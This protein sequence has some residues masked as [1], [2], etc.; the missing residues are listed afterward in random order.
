VNWIPRW[1]FAE[2]PIEEIA[3]WICACVDPEMDPVGFG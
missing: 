3:W 1:R 2:E